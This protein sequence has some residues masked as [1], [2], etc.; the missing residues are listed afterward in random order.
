[1]VNATDVA[2]VGAHDL[3]VL[4]DLGSLDHDVSPALRSPEKRTSGR[5]VSR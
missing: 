3:H 2:A 1:V 4:A 5:M